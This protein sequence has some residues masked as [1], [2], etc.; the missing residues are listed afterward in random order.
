M[1]AVY[2]VEDLHLPSKSWALKENLD[3]SPEA[4]HRFQNEALLLAMPEQ[5]NLPAVTDHFVDSSGEQYLA[6][7]RLKPTSDAQA[8]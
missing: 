6:K 3:T 2:L 5:A 7:L 8:V 1:G 4:I